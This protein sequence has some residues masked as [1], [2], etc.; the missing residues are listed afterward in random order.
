MVQ[1]ICSCIQSLCALTPNAD[2]DGLEETA[3][4]KKGGLAV[5]EAGARLTCRLLDFR[6][7]PQSQSVHACALA[8]PPLAVLSA[9]S[10]NATAQNMQQLKV[11]LSILSTIIRF[12]EDPS[13]SDAHHQ[14]C[15]VAAIEK[16]WP[17]LQALA[18]CPLGQ[19]SVVSSGVSE[20]VSAAFSAAGEQRGA[21]ISPSCNILQQLFSA[22]VSAAPLECVAKLAELSGEG[23]GVTPEQQG[24]LHQGLVGFVREAHTATLLPNQSQPD[25][26]AAMLTVLARWACFHPLA[27]LAGGLLDSA[28]AVTTGATCM[29]ERAVVQNSLAFLTLLMTPNR[30]LRELAAEHAE[31]AALLG[32]A[33]AAHADR[34]VCALLTSLCDPCPWDSWRS[35]GRVMFY[36]LTS[37]ASCEQAVPAAQRELTGGNFVAYQGSP[38]SQ[39]DCQRFAGLCL[40]AVALQER[41]FTAAVMD[42]AKIAHGQGD[43]D[44]LLAYEM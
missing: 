5:A 43:S 21:L 13:S 18:A 16:S 32:S 33:V 25:V 28:L 24:V 41:R 40:K 4:I 42:F 35:M 6:L 44:S 26:I 17:V 3:R 30:M 27:L 36:L 14:S 31:Q 37:A 34:M 23:S 2:S 8:A 20:V 7:S 29:R 19:N 22:N 12:L 15:V 38:L 9:A 1:G 39:N 11:C 10:Q